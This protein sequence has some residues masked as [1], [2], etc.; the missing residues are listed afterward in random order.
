MDGIYD[1]GGKPCYGEVDKKESHI[2][3][4]NRWEAA[5]FDAPSQ[6]GTFAIA[7]PLCERDFYEWDEFRERLIDE[8]EKVD[9]ALDYCYFDYFLAALVRLL[10]EKGLCKACNLIER[11]KIF[12]ERPHGRDHNH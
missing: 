10:Q 7:R 3:P 1:L 5:V 6:S 11:E 9:S 12:Q 2:V 8:I 4:Q